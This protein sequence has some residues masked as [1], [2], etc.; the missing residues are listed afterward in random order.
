MMGWTIHRLETA[1]D[2][3][4]GNYARGEDLITDTAWDRG[5]RRFRRWLR[6]VAT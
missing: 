6:R 1:F 3:V 2:R 4:V 5:V